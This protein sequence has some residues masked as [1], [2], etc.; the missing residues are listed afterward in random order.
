PQID[1]S[2]PNIPTGGHTFLLYA[3]DVFV[4]REREISILDSAWQRSR[5][6][7]IDGP[8]GMG[9]TSLASYWLAKRGRRVAQSVFAWSFT[10]NQSVQD[11]FTNA[12]EF[13]GDKPTT[14]S[15][16]QAA[17]G[18][19][20]AQILISRRSILILDDL[21]PLQGSGGRVTDES[22]ATLLVTLAV[23]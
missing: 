14:K 6:V 15:V 21:G 23:R 20:L 2:E 8:A 7:L 19:Q 4:G 9:K 12:I 16:A 3:P 18:V 13:F 5:L 22:L 17:L 1:E 10:H 11:F